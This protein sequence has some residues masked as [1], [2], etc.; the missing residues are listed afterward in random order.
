M[1]KVILIFIAYF[2]F[3]MS[4]SFFTCAA[5]SLQSVNAEKYVFGLLIG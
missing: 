2:H 4:L 1:F 5:L 3:I